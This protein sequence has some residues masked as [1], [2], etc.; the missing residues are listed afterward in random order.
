MWVEAG[1]ELRP[2]LDPSLIHR[3]NTSKFMLGWGQENSL[4][5]Q[6]IRGG[7][8]SGPNT[9]QTPRQRQESQIRHT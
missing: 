5:P 2:V 6:P 9:K 1:S 3:E 8:L 4:N 7:V